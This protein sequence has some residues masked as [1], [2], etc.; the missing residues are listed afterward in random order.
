MP[1]NFILLY[2]G[3]V[4]P[5]MKENIEV[6]VIPSSDITLPVHHVFL[7]LFVWCSWPQF[8]GKIMHV[9]VNNSIIYGLFNNSVK[10]IF[11]SR[12]TSIILLSSMGIS[13]RTFYSQNH[14]NWFSRNTVLNYKIDKLQPINELFFSNITEFTIRLS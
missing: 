11:S 4:I 5:S 8:P 13:R 7:L 10:I 2:C 3:S 12:K 14:D 9:L 6:Y 1:K